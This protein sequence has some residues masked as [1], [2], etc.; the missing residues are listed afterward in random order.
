MLLIPFE[1]APQLGQMLV[2]EMYVWV[3]GREASNRH[4]KGAGVEVIGVP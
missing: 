1:M 4:P 3:K 2:W